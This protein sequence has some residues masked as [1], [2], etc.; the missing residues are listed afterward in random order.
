MTALVRFEASIDTSICNPA[1]S[2]ALLG[3]QL[4]LSARYIQDLLATT[5]I[6][7]SERL[8]ELRLQD[9]RAMLSDSRFHVKRVSDIAFEV[10]FG[11][12]SYFNRSF[13][14]RFGCSPTAAR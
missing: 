4:G 5:G 2:A 10:G 7:F 12:I 6:G 8:L 11:D 3:L 13:R 9:A 14:R 1:L